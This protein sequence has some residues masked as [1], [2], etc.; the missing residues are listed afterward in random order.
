M[1]YNPWNGIIGVEFEFWVAKSKSDKFFFSL[2]FSV[3]IEKNILSV[4]WPILGYAYMAQDDKHATMISNYADLQRIMAND[5]IN[6][7]FTSIPNSLD[8][9]GF[10]PK[11]FQDPKLIK[12]R[13][14]STYYTLLDYSAYLGTYKL[15][16]HFLESIP[17]DIIE[18]SNTCYPLIFYVIRGGNPNILL[19]VEIKQILW[20][21]PQAIYFSLRLGQLDLCTKY[22]AEYQSI[23]TDQTAEDL[24]MSSCCK[25]LNQKDSPLVTAIKSKSIDCVGFVL[26]ITQR[27]IPMIQNLPIT[28]KKLTPL[29]VAVKQNCP[30]IVRLLLEL[31]PKMLTLSDS[32][33]NIPFVLALRYAKFPSYFPQF[34][35]AMKDSP[36]WGIFLNK[37]DDNGFAAIH[38]AAKNGNNAAIVALLKKTQIEINR[39]DKNGKTALHHAAM[40][41]NLQILRSLLHHPELNIMEYDTDKSLA[42][43]IAAQANWGKGCLEIIFEYIKRK[44]NPQNTDSRKSPFRAPISHPPPKQLLLVRANSVSFASPQK[45]FAKSS[46]INNLRIAQEL[47]TIPDNKGMNIMHLAAMYGNSDVFNAVEKKFGDNVAFMMD[48]Y[49]SKSQF[50]GATVLHYLAMNGHYKILYQILNKYEDL[51]VNIQ[52][53]DPV[54]SPLFTAA[55]FNQQRCAVIL[56]LR[57]AILEKCS[58]TPKELSSFSKPDIMAFI[59]QAPLIKLRELRL[60]SPEEDELYFQNQNA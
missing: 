4:F 1:A 38:Y 40:T 5:D 10:I 3:L 51:D 30:D 44:L 56:R 49:K 28:K 12:E 55:K 43:H 7:L 53:T 36:K 32:K 37:L 9:F 34:C 24:L 18:R 29:H 57:G 26:N 50:T 16:I 25:F 33:K 46:D 8:P 47:M 31:E 54:V 48:L 39:K 59:L 19:E 52:G 27:E 13:H 20:S 2:K 15:F 35:L 41:T 58:Q 21:S 45:V 60:F 14:S 17:R 6:L 22:F 11:E 23:H 42:V